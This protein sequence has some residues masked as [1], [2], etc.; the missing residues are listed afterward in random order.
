MSKNKLKVEFSYDFKLFG[1]ISTVKEYKLAWEIN[2]TLDIHL[3]KETDIQIEFFNKSDLVI[4]NYS[5]LRLLKN[6]AISSSNN[7]NQFL[8]PELSSFDY[9]ILVTG[10]EDTYTINS[11]KEK[12]QSITVIQ[13]LK[14]FEPEELKSKENLIF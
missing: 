5:E 9:L 2:K 4:S 12:L 11:L 10:F 13:Y 8:L 1:L 7:S 3:V 14:Q 6:K